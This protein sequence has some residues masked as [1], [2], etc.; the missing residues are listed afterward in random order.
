MVDPYHIT[1]INRLNQWK[2]GFKILASHPI[3]GVGDIDLHQLYLK[4][5]EPYEKETFGHLHNNYVHFI[6]I[7][8]VFGFIVVVYMLIKI[9]LLNLKIYK[10]VKEEEFISSYAL[11]TLAAFTGFLFSGLAEWNFGDH[12]IITMVWFTIGLNI[13]FY[14]LYLL[15]SK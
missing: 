1:N 10:T 2:T 6:V 4:Y 3:F 15:K 14:K 8:G 11:G 9:F 7:L 12:E 13:A 5:K